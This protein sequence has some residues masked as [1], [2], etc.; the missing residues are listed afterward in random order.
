MN[1]DLNRMTGMGLGGGGS[2]NSGWPPINHAALSKSL[3]T[4]PVLTESKIPEG[5]SN[6]IHDTSVDTGAPIG[7]VTLNL[8]TTAA[9]AIGN[10]C[11]VVA[12]ESWYEPSVLFGMMV[13]VP[14]ARKT[15]AQRPFQRAI[16]DTERALTA[17][18]REET[19]RLRRQHEAN[20]GRPKDFT[21]PPLPRWTVNDTTIESLAERS[22]ENPRG[23]YVN[24]DELA[25]WFGSFGRY[26]A[27]DL[28]DR[29]FYLTAYDASRFK[30]DRIKNADQPIIVERLN[31]SISGALVPDRLDQLLNNGINDGLVSRFLFDWSEP[32]PIARLSRKN[33]A[34]VLQRRTL[35][36]TA[37]DRLRTLDFDRRELMRE[38]PRPL[39][40]TDAAFL[41]FD[42]E[43]IVIEEKTRKQVGT[44]AEWLGKAGGRILRLA[45][46]YEYLA[47]AIGRTDL[48]GRELP[49]PTE[50]GL[51]ALRRAVEYTRYQMVMFRRVMTG[52]EP[53]KVNDD[54]ARLM[55]YLKENGVKT[56]AQVSDIG[57]VPGFRY[58][59][60]DSKSDKERRDNVLRLLGD[61]GV[62]KP[63][64]VDSKRGEVLKYA[65]NPAL[66]DGVGAGLS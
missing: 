17:G 31:L 10:T 20:G 19:K 62:I 5:W 9:S 11:I 57:R 12:T 13:G 42:E 4:A 15:A 36:K 22:A 37:L 45:L 40:L 49:P 51:D 16:E 52:G 64:Q 30:R 33:D 27:S 38:T 14:S 39:R 35:L 3:L 24:F 58:F 60:G 25:A 55:E 43:R 54:G 56:F 41:T 23:L 47:W 18:W 2:A 53:T 8:L 26:G 61:Y 29:G 34:G 7:Y 44:Y 46:V 28:G 32:L 1:D 21:P 66:F 59:R 6:W 63:A 65:V 48:L 50:V